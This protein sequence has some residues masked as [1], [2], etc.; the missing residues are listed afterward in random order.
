M[1]GDALVAAGI[2]QTRYYKDGREK[3]VVQD[4]FK[5]QVDALIKEDV[6]FLIAEVK[7]IQRYSRFMIKFN[8]LCF[9][10]PLHAFGFGDR[11]MLKR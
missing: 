6:D 8:S 10:L 11:N 3:H 9:D 5:K 4:E 7:C 2:T 1:E